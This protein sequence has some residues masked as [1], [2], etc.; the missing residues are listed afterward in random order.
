MK[1]ADKSQQEQKLE[2]LFEDSSAFEMVSGDSVSIDP[3]RRPIYSILW[4]FAL[5]M[6]TFNF[7]YLDFLFPTA[8]TALMLAGFSSLRE[9]NKYFKFAWYTTVFR[10]LLYILTMC[11]V[12][13]PLNVKIEEGYAD[14]W[15][16]FELFMSFIIPLQLLIFRAGINTVYREN[17]IERDR[18]PLLWTTVWYSCVLVLAIFQLQIHVIIGVIFIILFIATLVSL[19]KV[20]RHM[21]AAGFALRPARVRLSR[22][23]LVTIYIVIA[24]L[25]IFG[26]VLITGHSL[27]EI[28]KI[29]QS[30]D[31]AVS[32]RLADMGFPDH[33][34]SDIPKEQL[35]LIGNPVSLEYE[36]YTEEFD[37]GDK[38]HMETVYVEDDS[39]Q[40]YII[41]YFTWLE[42]APRWSDGL[43]VWFSDSN[44][45][46]FTYV[47]SGLLFE[48]DGE[49]YS[50]PVPDLEYGYLDEKPQNISVCGTVRYPFGAEERRG[51]VMT[52]VRY[53]EN[54]GIMAAC[55]DY[56]HPEHP[57]LVYSERGISA[58][59]GLFVDGF[60]QN[61]STYYIYSG[62]Y[63]E[64]Y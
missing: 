19:S 25:S 64:S 13:S 18:D 52:S 63:N 37:N 17:G 48:R 10:S 22:W 28:Y 21:S 4:G 61:Y 2:K 7:W 23:M 47:G 34:L 39:R 9:Q 44:I 29:E 56:Y 33:I 38:L 36:E 30:V 35:S 31:T 50:A 40:I 3:W 42:G 55:L 1:E 57:E 11:I 5:T 58:M 24:T 43:Y 6:V 26:V 60:C 16:V 46:D 32:Q 27:P 49:L 51:Y 59:N 53:D 15:Y 14:L 62:P 54:I 12:A 8:G 45:Q 41:Q 20:A